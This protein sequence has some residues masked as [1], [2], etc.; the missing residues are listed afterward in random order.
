[1]RI[2]RTGWMIEKTSSKA[3]RAW[4][5]DAKRGERSLNLSGISSLEK[6]HVF[7][8]HPACSDIM[9]SVRE[10]EMLTARILK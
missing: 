10:K 8:K 5:L 9:S 6:S 4:F 1:V 3:E 2:E 7:S